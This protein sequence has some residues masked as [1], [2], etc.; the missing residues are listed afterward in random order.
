MVIVFIT[1]ILRLN[2]SRSFTYIEALISTGQV[3]V[4]CRL[5]VSYTYIALYIRARNL[6]ARYVKWKKVLSYLLNTEM[7]RD[8]I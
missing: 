7:N 2:I 6:A 3:W 5:G 8:A 1:F 4:I